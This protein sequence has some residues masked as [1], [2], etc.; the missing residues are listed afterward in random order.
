MVWGRREVFGGLAHLPVAVGQ[1][2]LEGGVDVG[3]VERR[4]REHGAAS[5]SR[6]VRRGGKDGRQT[7]VVAVHSTIDP[8][9]VAVR[10]VSSGR[11]RPAA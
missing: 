1:G 2:A 10:S 9:A 4:Q 11:T 8:M 3:A 7:G 6:L 5:D